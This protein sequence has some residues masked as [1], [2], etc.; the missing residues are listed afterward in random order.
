LVKT[1]ERFELATFLAAGGRY[2]FRLF[3]LAVGAGV[4]YFLVYRLSHWLFPWIERSSRDVTT[5]TIVLAYNLG[6]ALLVGLLLILIKLVFDYAKIATVVEE[7]RSMAL[8]ALRGLGF[9]AAH[10]LKAF[11]VYLGMGLFSLGLLAAYLLAM[12]SV[13]SASPAIAVLAFVVGQAYQVCRWMLRLAYFGAQ[14][15]VYLSLSGYAT[16]HIPHLAS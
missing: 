9:V 13:S 5:E 4:A 14:T 2:F 8:A 7:R 3:R 6:A 16:R 11:G 10:P 12:P 15:T 1:G